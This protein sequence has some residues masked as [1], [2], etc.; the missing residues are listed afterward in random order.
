MVEKFNVRPAAEADLLSYLPAA[1]LFVENSIK[2]KKNVLVA[3]LDGRARSAAVLVA[4]FVKTRE[5]SVP[6]A[7]EL[8]RNKRPV[9]E[10]PDN[11]VKQLE[12]YRSQVRKS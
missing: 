12:A 5:I 10:L 1:V 4:Y 11:V 8:L 7:I 3:S 2:Q 9:I 6:Q